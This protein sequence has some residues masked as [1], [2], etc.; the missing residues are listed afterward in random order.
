M[1]TT[2]QDDDQEDDPEEKR[3][4][5]TRKFVLQK[6]FFAGVVMQTLLKLLYLM[7]GKEVFASFQIYTLKFLCSLMKFFKTVI[8]R[9]DPMALL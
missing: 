9:P 6:A 8:V 4:T 1:T 7:L 5:K 2:G 3:F